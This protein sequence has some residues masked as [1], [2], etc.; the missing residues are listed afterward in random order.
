MRIQASMSTEAG[1]DLCAVHAA[2][3]AFA[4]CDAVRS[5]FAS[6]VRTPRCYHNV[7]LYG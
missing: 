5:A 1:A 4:A 2:L 6:C 7:Q 3:D